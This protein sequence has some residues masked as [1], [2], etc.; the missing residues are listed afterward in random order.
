VSRRSSC[1]TCFARYHAGFACC[2]R[3]GA[4]LGAGGP[5]PLIGTVLGGRYRIDGVIGEGGLG[6]VYR[7]HH[8][9]MSRGFAIKVPFGDVAADPQMRARFAREA[10]AACRLSH[11]NVVAALDVGETAAGLLY[12][13]MEL[14]E[15]PTLEEVLEAGPLEP[16]RAMAIV[17]QIARG[18]A[19][20][21]ARGLVHRD[22][23][24]ANV[25]LEAGDRARIVDFGIALVLAD[26]STRLTSRGLVVGTPRYMAPEQALGEEIDARTDTF[27][28]GLIAYELIAGVLPHDGDGIEVALRYLTESLPPLRARAPRASVSPA[29]EALLARMLDKDPAARPADPAIAGELARLTTR[30][31]PK[32]CGAMSALRR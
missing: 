26:G 29:I 16:E 22:L 30:R 9:R 3:D 13:V 15:G 6:I 17:A 4:A 10:E 24:P 21:H 8:V 25:I 28:L 31:M 20:A 19:H 14:A 2:P 11:P 5:D 23:K 1:P 27:A 32:L 12:M 18:L 7:A